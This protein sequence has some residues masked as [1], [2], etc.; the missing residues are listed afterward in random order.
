MPSNDSTVRFR[1]DIS[2]LKAAMQQAQRQVRLVNSE[3]KAATAGMDDWTKSEE[4]LQAK[5]K[6]LN[7]VLDSQKKQL[8][9]LNQQLERTEQEYGKGSAEADRVKISINNM[10]AAIAK[11]EKELD[12]YNNQLEELPNTLEETGEAAQEASSG[13]S[14]MKGALADLVASGVKVAVSALKDFAQ[15]AIQVGMDY[16]SA[17][18]KVG[19]VSG[20]SAEDMEK[21]NAKAKE[22][23]ESTVFSATQS[24]EAFNYMAMAGWKTEDM[25][26]GIEGVMNLA[27]ASGADLA[28]TSDIVTDALT[29]MGYGAQDA[30]H[31]AD[32]MATAASNANTNV[33]MM[34][35]TFQYAAPLV[36]ALGYSME[37]TALAI[38][39]MANAGIKGEKA[40]TALRSIFNRLSAPP[41]ECAEE[42][43]RLGISLTDS[44]GNMKSLNEVMVKLTSVFSNLSET[45]QTAAAKHIAGAEAMS[46]LLAIVNASTDDYEKLSQAILNADGAAASMAETMNDNVGG[47]LTLL[48]SKIEGI[49]IKLFEKA[50]DSMK[51]GI[52]T[53]GD[54]LDSVDWDNVGEDIGEF[55]KKAADFFAYLVKNGNT[56][57]SVLKAIGTLIATVFVVNKINSS[58][59]AF[60]SLVSVFNKARTAT[61]ALNAVL[62]VLGI[63]M[64]ALPVMALIAGFAALVAGG[65][66][67]SKQ[68]DKDAEAAYGLTEK[69][70]ELCQSANETAEATKEAVNARKEALSSYDIEA[71]QLSS[72]VNQYN[73]LIDENGNVK[74]GYEDLADELL[75]DLADGLGTTIDKVKENIEANGKLGSSID[76]LIEKKKL[77]A[78]F[79]ALEE[80]YKQTVKDEVEAFKNMT[81]LQTEEAASKKK[82]AEAQEEYNK[83]VQTYSLYQN[84]A[85]GVVEKFNVAQSKK[86]LDE[87][88]ESYNKLSES[89]NNAKETWAQ[90]QSTIIQ[91]QD[92]VAA[93]TAQDTDKM[94]TALYSY[95]AGLVDSTVANKAQLVQQYNDTRNTLS[96]IEEMYKQ[97]TIDK[98]VVDS[99]RKMTEAAGGELDKWVEK[100]GEAG[101]AAAG[102]LGTYSQGLAALESDVARLSS[103]TFDVLNSNLGDWGAI[104][105]EKTGDYLHVMDSKAAAANTSGGN[106]ATETAAG[107]KSKSSEMEGAADEAYSKYDSTIKAHS[108]DFNEDGRYALKNVVEGAEDSASDMQKPGEDTTLNYSKGIESKKSEAKTASEKVASEAVSGFD[109][110]KE[111]AETSGNNFTQGFINGMLALLASVVGAA[112]QIGA[113][114][115]G[116]LQKSQKEGSPSKITFESGEFFSEGFT[117]GIKEGTKRAVLAA[118]DLGLS[119]VKSLRKAQQ[120]ASPSKLT[121]E[122]GRNFTLGFINGIVSL[123]GALVTKTK[124]MVSAVLAQLLKLN[125]FN[126]SEVTQ[127]AS[128]SF[129]KSLQKNLNYMINRINYSYQLQLEDFD[130]TIESLQEASDKAVEAAQNKSTKKQNKI[131]K[132]I[133]KAQESGDKKKVKSLQKKLKKEQ[134]AVSKATKSLQDS[135][136]AQIKEQ[137]K[138]KD[139]YSEAAQAMISE[140][141]DAMSEYQSAAQKLIDDTMNG[142]ADDYQSQYDALINKQDSLI[143]KLKSAGDL[144]NLS[145]ANVMTINDLQEQTAA[146]KQYASKLEDIKNKVS[147]DLFDQIA[148]YDMKEGEAF[149][150]RLLAMSEAELQAYSDAFDEKM[151]VAESLSKN[152]YKDDFDKIADNYEKAMKQAF[153]D[154]PKQLE[155]LGWQTMQGFLSGLTS[156]TDYMKESVKV[157]ISGMVDTFK[158]Q[159][160]IHSPSKVAFN[161]GELVGE[162]FA[163]GLKDMINTV[164]KAAVDVTDA[165]TDQLELTSSLSAAKNVVGASAVST[166]Y[167]SAGGFSGDKTQIINFTQNNNSPKALDRL[168]IYRQSE[169]LLFNAKVRLSNV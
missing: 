25:L 100:N 49:M 126:F 146:I 104:A 131:Q 34:G 47:K 65:V 102:S 74:E 16:E 82:L 69:Q 139:S 125:N 27:A 12:S 155:A 129:A 135:Y 148:S 132:K 59:V 169:S 11:T 17:M 158:Q 89:V 94:E 161:L 164:K 133:E 151:S 39:L 93:R 33:E 4:G 120:E 91:Y 144:F 121:Y 127:N 162:G 84:T 110:K 160:G 8:S 77:E 22:M 159:L 58:V 92:A 54:A 122:S 10:S 167:R 99:Y 87:A 168:T 46:G 88:Q 141:Q 35:A 116:S 78:K 41:K 42:M 18:S 3:F 97:G 112:A 108:S 70:K 101:E 38:G 56:I 30:G 66:A 118:A 48:K 117:N 105:E 13:F 142:I 154:L 14:V 143:E 36:G 62:S 73:E 53:V 119:S 45:E 95:E 55:A 134:T 76:E 83:A 60:T 19:A 149:M 9:L 37:D 2:Q 111:E 26:S 5:I 138:M 68:M 21:L 114:A 20:A 71:G 1:A 75:G 51:N 7:G 64:S 163:D 98:S 150:D 156:N 137:Q 24:A 81:K 40:G 90:A 6:Q 130:D 86:K 165:V 15:E 43:D 23:G 153:A 113:S 32:V 80:D 145:S 106:I 115:V 157:F 61:G 166:G 136:D 123:E 28:T 103:N 57:K 128:N 44:E 147:S 152:I 72:L 67:L 85:A 107:A 124:N 96:S 50:S 79:S 31:L 109:S 52:E 140:F 63:S 29:A